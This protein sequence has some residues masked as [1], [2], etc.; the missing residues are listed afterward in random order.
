MDGVAL[1][2]K[3]CFSVPAIPKGMMTKALW[4]IDHQATH[5][6]ASYDAKA[7]VGFYF[8]RKDHG[9]NGVTKITKKLVEMHEAALQGEWDRRVQDF[10]HLREICRA[11]HFVQQPMEVW[12][13]VECEGNPAG[14]V[15]DCKGCKGYGICS[16][17]LAANHIM[18]A[19]NLRRLTV[20]IGKKASKRP[21]G[22]L[23]NPGK[24]LQRTVYVY[25]SSDEEADRQ[26][27]M[28]AVGR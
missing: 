16:H 19:V 3:L 24:A 21:G 11:L 23:K 10:D 20:E 12:G 4:Y 5:V 1:P 28:G 15:C 13:C 27:G 8:L 6:H 7:E 17:V 26:I 22:N 9:L 18:K 14:Y 2:S 25:D